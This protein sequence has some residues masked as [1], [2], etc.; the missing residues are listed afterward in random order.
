MEQKNVSQL[1]YCC[2][3][4][5]GTDRA[6]NTLP[7]SP[8]N[9]SRTHT[10]TLECRHAAAVQAAA[11]NICRVQAPTCHRPSVFA[12]FRRICICRKTSNI[13]APRLQMCCTRK[14]KQ[15]AC[16][17]AMT[18]GALPTPPVVP[19]PPLYSRKK[20]LPW[21]HTRRKHRISTVSRTQWTNFW[22]Q[23]PTNLHTPRDCFLSHYLFG[24]CD[25]TKWAAVQQPTACIASATLFSRLILD[26]KY[27]AL[28]G[29]FTC[30]SSVGHEPQD[31]WTDW[32][33]K[34]TFV[35]L[36]FLQ[37]TCQVFIFRTNFECPKIL[38]STWVLNTCSQRHLNRP[39]PEPPHGRNSAAGRQ[40]PLTGSCVWTQVVRDHPKVWEHPIFMILHCW[41][42]RMTS[43]LHPLCT[44]FPDIQ[45]PAAAWWKI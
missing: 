31:L 25:I 32:C 16:S 8:Q 28:T 17:P 6:V 39:R 36:F 11:E 20:Q 35:A 44:I 1:I 40:K 33:I 45:G 37:K 21:I 43:D 15:L 19:V 3:R 7:A 26:S 42:E 27:D 5:A 22:S 2:L 13:H 10:S 23:W 14:K 29:S 34:A 12:F 9:L 4:S 41:Q 24:H 30:I 18:A 38:F